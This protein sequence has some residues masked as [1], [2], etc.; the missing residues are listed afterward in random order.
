[1]K[2]KASLFLAI[3]T[4]FASATTV[5]GFGSKAA[6]TEVKADDEEKEF[7]VLIWHPDT[8]DDVRTLVPPNIIA[9]DYTSLGNVEAVHKTTGVLTQEETQGVDLIY[10]M[11]CH[12]GLAEEE[13]QNIL[14]SA[15]VLSNF[16]S[17][18]GRL[19]FNGENPDPYGGQKAN[20]MFNQLGAQIGAHFTI[21]D[22][23]TRCSEY[24]RV[25]TLNTTDKPKLVR[26][27]DADE[28]DY[29]WFAPI[30]STS[31][32]CKWVIKGYK[33]FVFCADEAI[34]NGKLT[35]I[36][37]FDYLYESFDRNRVDYKYPDV[38]ARRQFL[39][40]L[41]YDVV[42]E[43]V[44]RHD[45][46]FTYSASED[47]ITATCSDP[48]C[49]LPNG[50]ATLKIKAPLWDLYYDTIE[51]VATVDYIYDSI[52]Q[53]SAIRYFQD[54][55]EVTKCVTC[56]HYVAEV[57]SNGQT[58]RV[59]FE[60]HGRRIVD[61][62]RPEVVYGDC[63]NTQIWGDYRLKVAIRDELVLFDYTMFDSKR[64]ADERIA[65]VYDVQLIS[66]DAYTETE[67]VIQPSDI[68]QD[69]EIELVLKFPDGVDMNAF[70]MIHVHSANDMEF[71]SYSLKISENAMS[72][73]VKRFSQFVF[74]VKGGAP[75]PGP[76]GRGGSGHACF[77]VFLM[78]LNILIALVGTFYVLLRLDILK[79]KKLN[80]I[81]ERMMKIE[82]LLTFITACALLA[83]F[84]LDL[85]VLI[86]HACAFTVIAFILGLLLLGAIMYWYIKTRMK[87]EMTP[88]EE[89]SVGKL[90]KKKAENKN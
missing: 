58:A 13:G 21:G 19:V 52:F 77:G 32:A 74:L 39:Q 60:I 64:K 75:T 42:D 86:A 45:H 18:G 51:R 85:I 61:P 69:L 36:A 70:R 56:G 55:E 3:T 34:G 8:Y 48:D 44:A 41:L 65:K 88:I 6:A 89:K 57:S 10:I 17:S 15:S 76:D 81:K 90:F 67:T 26:G 49:V 53:P 43:E 38:F 68:T 40:N 27:I 23:D 11:S 78:I 59:E 22:G 24:Q 14:N 9:Y 73:Q 2:K 31:D 72:I 66:Y 84:L 62:D 54:G 47:T 30:E 12:I 50:K 80:E 71:P 25:V 79:I 4:L 16:L 83:N 29:S 7:K 63:G 37:D 82:V 28:F 35:V 87:G 46:N 20:A 33:D 5:F 1:M